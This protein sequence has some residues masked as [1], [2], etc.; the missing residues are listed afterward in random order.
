MDY[1]LEQTNV[2]SGQHNG[3]RSFLISE[4][5]VSYI[6]RDLPNHRF[7]SIDLSK[8]L[9]TPGHIF[10]D[11][12]MLDKEKH[13]VKERIKNIMLKGGTTVVCPFK[14]RYESE[15]DNTFKLAKA[16]MLNSSIDYVLGLKLPLSKLSTDIIRKC[17]R[18][19]LPFIIVEVDDP[20]SI[21]ITAWS[22]I[23]E[24]LF[25]YSISIIPEFNI[26]KMSHNQEK[27]IKELWEETLESFSIP[28]EEIEFEQPVQFSKK[29]VQQFGIYPQ[30][31]DLCI[32][33]DVDYN[34]YPLTK[35]SNEVEQNGN[36]GYDNTNQKPII[37]IH[38]GRVIRTLEELHYSPGFG[39]RLKI[40]TPGQ[41]A[42]LS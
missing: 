1:L 9:L 30:K 29:V 10:Y 24:A 28:T 15:F 40:K 41:F 25:P 12:H 26:P 31:G 37:T 34:L 27:K 5:K 19:Y 21:E 2:V 32:G 33:S 18:N 38:K 6:F 22:W 11:H 13:E 8:Y 20:V 14:I 36:I 42:S 3:T 7:M 39:Q 35:T 4:N 23:K 17:K 16:K